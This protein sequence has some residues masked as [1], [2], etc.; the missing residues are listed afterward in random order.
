M[1]KAL[2]ELELEEIIER[3]HIYI[4]R[5]GLVL[6]KDQK[7]V[8]DDKMLLILKDGLIQ[9][10]LEKYK[11]DGHKIDNNLDEK[12]AYKE[13]EFIILKF[14]YAIYNDNVELYRKFLNNKVSLGDTV[15]DNKIYLLNKELS[16]AFKNDKEYFDFIKVFNPSIKR[17]YASIGNKDTKTRDSYIESFINI[18]KS[19]K[20]Y[21]F[22]K[23]NST[24]PIYLDL[25]NS[26]NIKIFGEELLKNATFKQKE[27]INFSHSKVSDVNLE[28][29]KFLIKK[30]PNY[31]MVCEFE[32]EFLNSFTIDEIG[33][34]PHNQ[35]I[36]L[37]KAAKEKMV[38]QVLDVFKLKPTFDCPIKMI[39]KEIFDEIP[40]DT[41][42]LL[43]DNAKK[44]ICKVKEDG[45]RKNINRIV[46]RDLHS[47]KDIIKNKIENR[48]TKKETK[49]KKEKNTEKKP[50]RK[51]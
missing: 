50:G 6:K 33:N 40:A 44:E 10:L 30:Y 4:S 37:N 24:P 15:Y 13:I 35:T 25:L 2:N 48:K 9:E 32:D 12:K 39:R 31:V 16:D 3:L 47:L 34:M 46:N 14:Y 21:L 29:V 1:R 26:R 27:V 28:K 41:M 22:R 8:A 11:K 17:F 5:N 42:I 19:D 45:F 20:R 38:P 7:K 43:S 51:K 23:K 49:E 36:I 18:I